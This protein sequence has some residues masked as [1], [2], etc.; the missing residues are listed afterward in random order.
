MGHM[1]KLKSSAPLFPRCQPGSKSQ[2]SN[3]MIGPSGDQD[4]FWIIS[5]TLTQVQSKGL[6]NKKDTPITWEILR[7]LEGTKADTFFIMQQ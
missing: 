1:I 6:M 2:S 3:Y 4:P 5:L 7:I